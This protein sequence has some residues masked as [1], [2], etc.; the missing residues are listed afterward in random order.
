MN[1]NTT[2]TNK[3][4]D[5]DGGNYRVMRTSYGR[6][7]KRP[8][9]NS[10]EPGTLVVVEVQNSVRWSYYL[11]EIQSDTPD[12]FCVSRPSGREFKK[13]THEA[14]DFGSE[15]RAFPA[16]RMY[17]KRVEDFDAYA[18]KRDLVAKLK[19]ANWDKMS[20]ETLEAIDVFVIANDKLL[21]SME[22]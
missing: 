1:D 9:L 10:F 6:E 11:T 19:N 8:L 7:W 16:N 22:A 18:K 21:E 15:I 4:N 5:C 14:V 13:D 2:N 3:Q 12:T 17:L 20:L